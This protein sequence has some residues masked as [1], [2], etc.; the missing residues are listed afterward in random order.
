MLKDN[1]NWSEYSDLSLDFILSKT[2]KL[3]DESVKSYRETTNKCYVAFAF[4][5]S[6]IA[7]C[8]NKVLSTNIDLEIIPYA[9]CLIGN[10]ICIYVLFETLIPAKIGFSGCCPEEV[11]IEDFEGFEPK[12][13]ERYYKENFINVYNNLTNKNFDIVR[14]RSK[15]FINSI[16]ILIAA[17][18]FS[19]F[20]W[21][22]IFFFIKCQS[23]CP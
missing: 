12:E 16:Y 3:L 18:L 17:F 20:V 11:L 23:Y 14:T 22:V 13:Q 2:E 19:A 1:I 6:T 10:S 8:L 4:Y 21:L 15:K 7:Y 9:I 5:V